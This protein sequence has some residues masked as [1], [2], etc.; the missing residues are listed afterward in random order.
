MRILIIED[1]QDLCRLICLALNQ[2][3]YETD[4]CHTGSDGLFYAKNQ[5]YDA[6][7]LDRMLPEIDGFTVLTALRRQK[8]HTPVILATALGSLPDR[9]SGLDAG[10][11]DYL[12][13]PFAMEEL[14]ARIRRSEEHTSELQS[15]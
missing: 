13:K 11:D 10:A 3:G 5:A 6:I 15:R 8:I 12:V 9:V 2:A 4:S 14:T 1:D 7:I